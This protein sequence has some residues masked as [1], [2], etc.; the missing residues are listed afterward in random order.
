MSSGQTSIFVPITSWDCG[1]EG[2]SGT[3]L[4]LRVPLTSF[5]QGS[6][7]HG[8]SQRQ[9]LEAVADISFYTPV[10]CFLGNE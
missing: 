6:S 5:P 1:V 3:H 9:L 4:R 2:V 8:A 10:I 7:A